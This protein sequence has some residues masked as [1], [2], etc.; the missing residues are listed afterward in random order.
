MILT[1]FIDIPPSPF[2]NLINRDTW[3][4][5]MDPERNTNEISVT[6]R[7]K[8][9]AVTMK[10]D[11]TL[12]EL[13]HELQKLT[14]VKSDTLKLIVQSH[15]SSKLFSPFSDEH[16][17]LTLLETS[18][19]EG[20]PIRMMGVPKEE[21]DQILESSRKDTRIAGFDEE[22]KRMRQR[23]SNGFDTPL[24]LPQGN[25]I[26]GDFKTLDLPGIKL[27]PPAS[28]ALR[29]M[30]TL[31]A[32]RGIVAVMNKHKWRVGI[33]TEMAPEGYVGVSPV[34]ILGLNKNK[35]EEISLRLRTDDLKGFRKYQSIKKT[36]LHE[37]AHMVFSEHD[38][39]FYALDKQLN[40]EANALDW[41]RSTAHTLSG[42]HMNQ[43][44]E[45]DFHVESNNLSHKLGGDKS[46]NPFANNPRASSVTAA[47][48]R[49]LIAS[50]NPSTTPE[51]HQEP[52]PDD[53][54]EISK[55][56]YE[57]D[58]DDVIEV[59]KQNYEP[60]PDDVIEVSKQNYEPD[61]DDVIEV[62]KQNY[63]PDPDDV[64]EIGK[65]NYEPDPDDVMEAS[66]QNYEPDPDDVMEVSKQNYEPDPDDVMEVGKQN[67]GPDTDELEIG[68]QNDE[69]DPDDEELQR[70]QDPVMVACNR[71]KKS[72]QMLQSEVSDSEA[73]MVF[74]TLVKIVKNVIEHPDEIK[75]KKLRKANPVIQKNIASYNGAM[76][77]LFLVGFCED[78]VQDEIGRAEAY[79]VLKRNDPGLLW[80]A[81]SSLETCVAF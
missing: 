25:Y 72:I 60:D 80:L 74:K 64:M 65:Q 41:T 78:V 21:V 45:P 76:E 50:N 3:E 19:L 37:L 54:I 33:M 40:L 31:A 28:E 2:L 75:F 17:H 30:H 22:E 42:S 35:G 79:L 36:L 61:P 66:K 44:Y 62:D 68:K 46:N 8:K 43:H 71:L 47:Y 67:Y 57:P 18:I 70:I 20:K 26:F 52:D 48:N 58:P 49:L 13:G 69:P 63:E 16:S 73:V 14:A 4:L 29:L 1:R 32:D 6:W 38:A 11:A 9:Y 56:N 27:N 81:K 77:I 34:C 39:N 53:V 10:S 59:S 12:E 51:S 5:K 15:K 55:Q 7:G 24:K 23:M